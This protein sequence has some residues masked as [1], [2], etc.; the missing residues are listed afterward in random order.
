[1][2]KCYKCVNVRNKPFIE[3]R[4]AP[5]RLCSIFAALLAER[6]VFCALLFMLFLFMG[7]LGVTKGSL[8]GLAS[9]VGDGVLMRD[10][11]KRPCSVWVWTPEFKGVLGDAPPID[12]ALGEADLDFGDF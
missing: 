10:T 5:L 4:D 2:I 3:M 12:L 9:A 11:E 6:G 7:I 8:T 1:M